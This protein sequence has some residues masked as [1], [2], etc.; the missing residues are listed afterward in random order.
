MIFD[1][2]KIK[3]NEIKN[4]IEKNKTVKVNQYVITKIPKFRYRLYDSSTKKT[5]FYD[6]LNLILE[7]VNFFEKNKQMSIL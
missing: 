3:I 6:S 2:K 4:L 7:D 1:N 5:T